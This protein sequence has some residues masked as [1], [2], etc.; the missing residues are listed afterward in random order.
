M[1]NTE[2]RKSKTLHGSNSRS[3]HRYRKRKRNTSKSTTNNRNFNKW[4]GA[5]L[6]VF[7][8]VMSMY[9]LGIFD[10][11]GQVFRMPDLSGLLPLWP[12]LIIIV[13]FAFVL[14]DFFKS[15]NFK[16]WNGKD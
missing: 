16:D 8:L 10:N 5:C 13:G 2:N 14:K 1:D 3:E 7:G 4:M 15:S 12:I 9:M 6:I 11:P